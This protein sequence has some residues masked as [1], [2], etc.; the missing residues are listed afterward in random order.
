MEFGLDITEHEEGFEELETAELVM[1]DEEIV[2]PDE[3]DAPEKRPAVFISYNRQHDERVARHLYGALSQQYDVYLDQETNNIGDNYVLK[4]DEWLTLADFFIILI[5]K[6]S[7]ES[8]WVMAELQRAYQLSKERGHPKMLPIRVAYTGPYPLDV[9]A[10]IG[11]IHALFWDDKNIAAHVVRIQAAIENRPPPVTRS[12]NVGMDGMLVGDNRRARLVET[13]TT[14]FGVEGGLLRQCKLLWLTGD[15]DVRNYAALSLAAREENNSLYEVTRSRSWTEVNNTGVSDSVI[16]LRDALPSAN[17]EEATAGE[18]LN[19]LRALIERKN[20]VV[21]TAP[22]EEFERVRQE[23][24]RYEFKDYERRILTR[25][26]YDETAKLS[27]FDNLLDYLL[28]T[29]DLVEEQS[30][31]ARELESRPLFREIIKKW[32]PSDIER[33]VVDSLPQAER[34]VDVTRLLQRNA[35]LEDEIHA[36]FLSLDDSTRCFVLTVSLFPE[37]E[38]DFLWEKYKV[39]VKDLRRLD[40]QLALQPFG[41]CR[42]RASRYI[43]HEGPIYVRDERVAEAIRQEITKNYREYFIELVPRL[44][45]WTVPAGREAVPQEPQRKLKVK[46]GRDVRRAIARTVGCAGRLGLEDLAGILEYWATDPAYYVRQAVADALAE[47]ARSHN[48]ISHALNLLEGWSRDIA[49]KGDSPRRA[50]AAAVAFGRL[51]SAPLDEYATQR[52]LECVRRLAR[53]RSRDVRFNL[54]IALREMVRTI[55]VTQLKGVLAQVASEK[56]DNWRVSV[57]VNVADAL[58]AARARGPEAEE[59]WRQWVFAPEEWWRWTAVCALLT[60]RG[61]KYPPLFELLAHDETAVEVAV[62]CAEL[63]DHD[64]HGEVV[65][66]TF[67]RLLNDAEGQARAGLVAALASLPPA[68]EKKLL[69]LVRSY[70]SPALE[71]QLVEVRRKTLE[72]Q[73]S[74]P[75]LFAATLRDWLARESAQLEVFKAFALLVGDGAGNREQVV[76]TL[77]AR[78][79]QDPED[80]SA[81]LNKLEAMAPSN[82]AFLAP[83]VR[84]AVQAAQQQPYATR[85]I[86]IRKPRPTFVTKLVTRLFMKRN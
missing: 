28:R 1:A 42:Q 57:R 37:T 3:Q 71:E 4:L 21:A 29:G 72:E 10:Y 40:P 6:G 25:N 9:S 54:S 62:V 66:H 76:S 33:F 18:E 32:S 77:A 50:S 11:R 79:A 19:S 31:W 34:S 81:L 35:A 8:G 44:R 24:Q 39:I 22:D 78:Y 5:S 58:N 17:F 51:A 12:L 38:S 75:E 20:I 73:L 55:P 27:I 7:L 14:P 59:L 26:S 85:P 83:T 43:S 13:F 46:E 64:F 56:S 60:W 68:Q 65:T 16:V 67:K 52:L 80:T 45:E 36:W 49:P 86:F 70:G 47:T 84:L 63:L 48:G 74:T 2:V 61:D 23:M 53:S 82:F 69:S 15:A 41:I 30:A